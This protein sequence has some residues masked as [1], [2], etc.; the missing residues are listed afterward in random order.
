M[1]PESLVPGTKDT[2]CMMPHAHWDGGCPTQRQLLYIFW[3]IRTHWSHLH[4]FVI[5][6]QSTRSDIHSREDRDA[7]L[8]K[9]TWIWL[10][11]SALRKAPLCS[12]SREVISSMTRLIYHTITQSIIQLIFKLNQ[13]I[14]HYN[15]LINQSII[16]YQ[17]F[18]NY[19]H[20]IS[21]INLLL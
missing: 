20:T 12:G 6:N 7:Y 11:L 18:S 3:E 15:H 9:A 1:L 10:S 2:D 16:H 17:Y 19:S 13:S 14:I 8:F 4:D 21:N 5:V